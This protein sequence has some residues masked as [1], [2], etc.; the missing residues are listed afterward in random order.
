[1]LE[2]MSFKS[3]PS[4]RVKTRLRAGTGPAEQPTATDNYKS[5]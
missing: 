4:V 2:D 3:S 5:K 1:M